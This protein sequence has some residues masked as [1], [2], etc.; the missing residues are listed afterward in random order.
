MNTVI[1]QI[2]QITGKT[3]LNSGLTQNRKQKMIAR[4]LNPSKYEFV[5]F[6]DRTNQAILRPRYHNVRNSLGQFAAVTEA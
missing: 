4:H 6:L 2:E 1:K 3:N 5:G